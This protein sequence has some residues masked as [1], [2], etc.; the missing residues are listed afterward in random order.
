[1]AHLGLAL[2]VAGVALSG[3]Y[4]YHMQYAVVLTLDVG[5][6]ALVPLQP[7]NDVHV[8]ELAAYRVERP[9]ESVSI[10]PYLTAYV[11]DYLA[12]ALG[13]LRGRV[14]FRRF[15][16][17]GT[18]LVVAFGDFQPGFHLLGETW[19]YVNSTVETPVGRLLVGAVGRGDSL[20]IF[21]P[22]PYNLVSAVFLCG[23]DNTALNYFAEVVHLVLD[24]SPLSLEIRYEVAGEFKL[25]RGLVHGVAAVPRGLDD[26]YIAATTEVA[27]WRNLTVH[28]LIVSA[29]RENLNN[30]KAL[31]AWLLL[32]TYA[33]KALTAEEAGELEGWSPRD[34]CSWLRGY[35]L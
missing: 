4:S 9:R 1:L 15:V 32:S 16:V 13:D 18:E 23:L 8:V 33:G 31:G 20:L 30:C 26:I 22:T 28:R 5:E 17:N 29:A 12:R 2:L 19:I 11:G 34:M 3:P 6:S 14:E 27:Q 21:S 35:L 25:V 7:F 10:P 24:G